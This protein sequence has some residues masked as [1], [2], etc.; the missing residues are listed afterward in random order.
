[1]ASHPRNPT[2]AKLQEHSHL[3]HDGQW[4][5]FAPGAGRHHHIDEAVVAMQ[6]DRESCLEAGCTGYITKPVN[7]S[8]TFSLELRNTHRCSLKASE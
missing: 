7:A 6:G 4:Y 5:D 1:M 2:A 3:C 8:R